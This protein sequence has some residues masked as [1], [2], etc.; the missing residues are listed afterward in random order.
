[1]QQHV[2]W[3][4]DMG[5]DAVLVDWTNNLWGD[6]EWSQRKAFAQQLINATTATVEFYAH[7]LREQKFAPAVVLLLGLDNGINA[8]IPALDG[9]SSRLSGEVLGELSFLTLW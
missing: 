2:H 3:M 9:G 7:R 5:V 4:E 8:S 1:M 6:S